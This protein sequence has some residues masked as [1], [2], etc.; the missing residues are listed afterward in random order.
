M[1]TKNRTSVLVMGL[2]MASSLPA[3]SADL[4]TA[5]GLQTKAAPL[6]IKSTA[7]QKL[8]LDWDQEAI[9]PVLKTSTKEL[10]ALNKQSE[11]M[12]LKLFEG[13]S[14]GGGGNGINGKPIESYAIDI[15]TLTS[16]QNK[17]VAVEKMIRK[18]LP[19]FV[20][21]FTSAARTKTWYFVPVA[22]QQLSNKT[23]GA[24][25][26]G[27]TDQMAFQTAASV[28]V[29][30]RKF[31]AAPLARQGDLLVHEL[32]MSLMMD[33][34][35]RLRGSGSILD[36][37]I[38]DS[39][40][41]SI[42]PD[43]YEKIRTLTD[44]LLHKLTHI[45]SKD[46]SDKLYDL[47]WARY[48]P[49]MES[50]P[51][52]LSEIA[53]I[54]QSQKLRSTKQKGLLPSFLIAQQMGGWDKARCRY[55]IQYSQ[56]ADTLTVSLEVFDPVN[57][58]QSPSNSGDIIPPSPNDTI[59]AQRRILFDHGASFKNKGSS[60]VISKTLA[61]PNNPNIGDQRKV[62]FIL[63]DDEQSYRIGVYFET[64]LYSAKTKQF[65]WET[66]LKTFPSLDEKIRDEHSVV[67]TYSLTEN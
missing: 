1:K 32:V 11:D 31:Q 3:M 51:N 46:L 61:Q 47:I 54:L 2:L 12:K 22:L 66:S 29:D 63:F 39:C 14:N 41:L 21:D 60:M 49:P 57:S 10:G 58:S 40:D 50:A 17:V 56:I 38:S 45:S 20:D 24:P 37:K 8:K 15:R 27:K 42:H 5:V 55:D 33:Y 65:V 9:K 7:D 16:Y 30:D 35:D 23:I 26:R 64:Y 25:I 19:D 53:N 44:L 36:C 13:N 18:K 48:S 28:W 62:A 67:C 52:S 4:L 6:L 59:R 43:E 34:V